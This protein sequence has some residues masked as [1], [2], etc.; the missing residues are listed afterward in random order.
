MKYILIVILIITKSSFLSSAQLLPNTTWTVYDNT[1]TFYTY[2]HFNNDT[3]SFSADNISYYNSSTFHESGN[4]FNIVNLAGIIGNTCMDTGHY[5]F[6]IQMDT[7]KFTLI[8]DSC[9]ANFRPT[10]ISVY[11]WIRLSVGLA[12]NSVINEQVFIS[13][14]PFNAEA[15]INFNQ[16]QKNTTIKI[17]DLLGHEVKAI[18][19]SGKQYV[20]EKEKMK[21]GIYCVQIM[22]EKKNLVNKKIVVQ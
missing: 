22:D 9:T 1:N 20:I 8:N 7:L 2:F 16:E 11:H 21:A 4:N 5:T 15:T 3:L 19:F 13:P 10:I 6:L 12:E 17:T 14:N 18:N